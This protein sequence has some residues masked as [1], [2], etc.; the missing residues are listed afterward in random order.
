M[1]NTAT[2]HFPT[3]PG[4]EVEEIVYLYPGQYHFAMVPTLIHTLLGSCVSVALFHPSTGYGALCHGILPTDA[5]LKQPSECG[6]FMDCAID[7]MMARFAEYRIPSHKIIAKIF[8][9]AKMFDEFETGLSRLPGEN[10]V[11]VARKVL[12]EYNCT[13]L[14]E[15]CGGTSGRKIFFCSH[16]GD[17]FLKRIDKALKQQ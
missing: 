2:P 17:V 15:D 10:N 5:R 11:I 1:G 7:K 12:G 9:G 8:G 14:S 4:A 16:S 13:I 6:K 3:C